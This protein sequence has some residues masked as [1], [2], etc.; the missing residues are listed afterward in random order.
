MILTNRGRFL[1][2]LPWY[3][4]QNYHILLILFKACY[5]DYILIHPFPIIHASMYVVIRVKNRY[6]RIDLHIAPPH[7]SS[8]RRSHLLI[9]V[10]VVRLVAELLREVLRKGLLRTGAALAVADATGH[11]VLYRSRGNWNFPS[12]PPMGAWP[13]VWLMLSYV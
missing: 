1:D 5:F 12:A 11:G 9:V 2:F 13:C 3:S 10:T 6:I 8:P 7:N 4:H